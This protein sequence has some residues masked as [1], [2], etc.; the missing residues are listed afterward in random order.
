MSRAR[1]LLEISLKPERTGGGSLA[2][3]IADQIRLAIQSGVLANATVMPS[4]RALAEQLGVSRG[5]V[6]AAYERLGAA[7]YLDVRPRSVPRVNSVEVASPVLSY[8]RSPVYDFSAVAPDLSLFPRREWQR[9]TTY[10]IRTAPNSALDYGSAEGSPDLRH[11]LAN[12][13]GR[14]RGVLADPRRIIV[15][16]GFTQALQIVANVLAARG[17]TTMAIENPSFDGS[18]KSVSRA[19]LTPVPLPVDE[20]GARVDLLPSLAPDA[21]LLTP[22]HQ[23]PIGGVLNGAR[24]RSLL[25]WARETDAIV[26]E[27]DYNAE[28]RYD[29]TPVTALQGLAPEHVV[30]AGSVSKTLAPGL[31]LGWLL[32]PQAMFEAARVEKW[33][34]DY[35]SP[36]LDQL[37]FAQLLRSGALDEHLRRSRRIYARRRQRFVAQI[38]EFLPTASVVGSS[39]GLHVTALLKQEIDLAGFHTS[40][41]EAGISVKDLSQYSFAPHRHGQGIV[42]GYG[43]IPETATE[44]ALTRLAALVDAHRVN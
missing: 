6:T 5:V 37:A 24:R 1:F 39:A 2:R 40:C 17:A 20:R 26:I 34:M 44:S 30:Y 3:Q 28:Y 43:R 35:G 18:F 16:Q 15:T 4:S 33:K 8:P 27:D 13:L 12:Y 36:G 22:A 23:F 32:A 21:V 29:G 7:G 31:R 25:G 9:A 14:V 10:A 11:E 19:G 42:L 38:H 41:T